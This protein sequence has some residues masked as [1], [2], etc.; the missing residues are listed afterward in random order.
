[1]IVPHTFQHPLFFT[2]NFVAVP[3]LQ[4]F[5]LMMKHVPFYY[6]MTQEEKPWQQKEQAIPAIFSLWEEEKKDLIPLFA[7]RQPKQAKDAMV[8]GLSYFLCALCWL[9]GRAVN[10]VNGW[11]K[12]VESL[13]LR[14]LNVVD[15]LSFIFARP[16][17]HHSFVQ[18]DELFIELT[19]L[20]Y[21]QLAK[22]KRD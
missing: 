6:D 20:F 10:N 22:Q 4:P 13:L 9:N 18:L 19:K 12:E 5:P 15:R 21:K 11:E 8:R 1:M 14:P 16:A 2:T 17:L 3:P 7:A